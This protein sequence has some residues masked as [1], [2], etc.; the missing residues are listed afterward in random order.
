MSNLFLQNSLNNIFNTIT[1]TNT[2]LPQWI[3]I[4][5]GKKNNNMDGGSKKFKK[6]N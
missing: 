4:I 2:D 5:D 1:E 6:I 3:N